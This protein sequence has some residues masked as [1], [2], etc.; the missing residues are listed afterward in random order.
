[1]TWLENKIDKW[2]KNIERYTDTHTSAKI[3]DGSDILKE[4]SDKERAEYFEKTMNK[5]EREIPDE[6][7]R[8]NILSS[9][10]CVFT[11]EFGDELIL[12][13]REIYKNTVKIEKVLERMKQYPG[14]FAHTVYENGVVR[15]KRKPRDPVAYAS[16]KTPEER[17]LAACF[18]PLAR[19]GNVPFPK[20]FCYCSAGWYKGIWEGILDRP[21]KVKVVK[22]LLY[23]DE[24]CEFEI[25][26]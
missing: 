15:E 10:S 20:P 14:K 2:M 1:M 3:M 22:S 23:G 11:E 17:K 12:E 5:L 18:C 26:F 25:R 8:E 6:E 7:T 13:L 21:V 4:A 9:C 24:T 16:A 19:A